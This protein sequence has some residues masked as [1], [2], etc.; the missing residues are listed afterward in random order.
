MTRGAARRV[1]F[2][3]VVGL[4]LAVAAC[5]DGGTGVRGSGT[6]VSE[7]RDVSEFDRIALEGGG[8]L[9]ITVGDGESLLLSAEDNLLPLLTTEVRDG[10][11]ELSSSESISPTRPIVYTIEARELAGVSVTGSGD[12]VATGIECATFGLDVTGSGD[13]D[14]DGRCDRLEVAI[15]GSGD[16]DGAELEVA[17]ASISITGS[18]DVV[19]NATDELMVRISGSGDVRYLGDPATDVD[20][21]GA[22]DVDRL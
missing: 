17:E 7:E 19:V 11:L 16:L 5:D 2:G 18:G 15:A 14:L 20:I 13:V 12:V 3:L 10:R 6:V 8:E 1:G 22:G 9:S 4:A 21:S